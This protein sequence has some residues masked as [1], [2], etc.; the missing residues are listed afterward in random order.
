VHAQGN[1]LGLKVRTNT[2]VES[3][4]RARSLVR[5]RDMK[6]NEASEVSYDRLVLATGASPIKPNLPGMCALPR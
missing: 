2:L 1:M 5:V 4:D 3:I 6:T